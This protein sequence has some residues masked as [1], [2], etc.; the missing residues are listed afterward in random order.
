MKRLVNSN[1]EAELIT[2]EMACKLTNLG[3]NSV[4]KLSE[5]ARAGLKIGK[6]YRIKK[7]IFLNYLNTF[8]L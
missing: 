7:T 8:E 1:P 3:R 4:R 2:V 5:D 6:C